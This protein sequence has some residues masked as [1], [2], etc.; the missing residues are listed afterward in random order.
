MGIHYLICRNC[1]EKVE[2]SVERWGRFVLWNSFNPEAPDPTFTD[3]LPI[4]TGRNRNPTQ[5]TET[6]QTV[7]SHDSLVIRNP[8]FSIIYLE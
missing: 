4:P 1:F 8:P 2:T 5:K 7:S 3:T 6:S